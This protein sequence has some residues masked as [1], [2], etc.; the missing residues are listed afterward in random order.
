[1]IGFAHDAPV[2]SDE[3]FHS[4]GFGKQLVIF[5]FVELVS[6]AVAGCA[7]VVV[8]G[9]AEDAGECTWRALGHLFEEFVGPG[10]IGD[11]RSRG[12]E[13]QGVTE[14]WYPFGPAPK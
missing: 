14:L 2:V 5:G 1:M 3:L 7:A 13:P 11:V 9:D 4:I 6:H 10:V 8:K 12:D